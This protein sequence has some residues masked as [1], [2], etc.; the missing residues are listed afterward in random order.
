MVKEP[1][2]FN[3]DVLTKDVM[4]YLIESLYP[5]LPQDAMEQMVYFIIENYKPHQYDNA[6]VKAAY[7]NYFFNKTNTMKVQ[8]V[9]NVKGSNYLVE[10][11]GQEAAIA[12]KNEFPKT[13]ILLKG[14]QVNDKFIPID[15]S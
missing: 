9:F 13:K 8:T 3:S 7:E 4:V 10:G 2:S 15:L 6:A 11:S 5:T 12:I 1:A 14:F